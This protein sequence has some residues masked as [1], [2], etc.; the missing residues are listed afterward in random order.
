M[1]QLLC[2]VGPTGVGKTTLAIEIAKLVPSILVSADSRQVYRG[3]DIVTG[4]DHPQ[5]IQIFGID[6][7]EPNEPCSVAVWYDAVKPTIDEA[8]KAEKLVIIV[9][10]TGL[11]LRALT[12]GI[13]TMQVPI[14]QSLRDELASYSRIELHE[15]LWGVEPEKFVEMNRSDQDNPRRLI[16]AIEV[17][18]S[19]HDHVFEAPP[20]T[21]P[22]ATLIGLRPPETSYTDLVTARVRARLKEGAIEETQK[23][24]EKYGKEWQSFSAIGYRSI[25]AFLEGRY[26]EEEMVSHWVSDELAYAKR[27]LTWFRGVPAIKWYDKGITG[28]EVYADTKN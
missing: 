5:N 22:T 10:G 21:Q 9:G 3:M 18:E 24:L 14:N 23:L 15:R 26:T 16:R 4:K 13:P 11:Y 20:T 17:A 25:I 8:W 7:C 2:I 28:Q 1:N 6:I 12:D 19:V 27:Q